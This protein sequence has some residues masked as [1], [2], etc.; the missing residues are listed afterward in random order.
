LTKNDKKQDRDPMIQKSFKRKLTAILNYG[1]IRRY[2]EA[3]QAF[4]QLID[5]GRKGE[6]PLDWG[7]MHLAGVYAE[8]DR[9][10]RPGRRWLQF[11]L[12]VKPV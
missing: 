11:Q 8:Q 9:E 2:E 7:L 12:Y 6:C 4:N 3:L 1:F 5:C 10:V